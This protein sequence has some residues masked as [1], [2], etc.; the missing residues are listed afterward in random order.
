MNLTRRVPHFRSFKF[1]PFVIAAIFLFTNLTGFLFNCVFAPSAQAQMSSVTFDQDGIPTDLPTSGDRRL[2]LIIFQVGARYGVDPRLLHVVIWKESK[3]KTHAKSHAGAQGLMQIIPATA[4]RFD[5]DDVYDP[6]SNIEA[7]TRYLRWLLERFD[8][9][10]KL[11]LAGY[12]AGEGSV[13]KYDGVPPY[14]ETQ[15]YVRDIMDC[16]GKKFH[17][18]LAPEEARIEFHLAQEVAQLQH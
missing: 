7:G 1:T 4:R 6:A 11:A 10:I 13:D 2:D 12:N 17:P 8:G 9:D 16:Y 15:D 3:Y 5:C 18:V 14:D